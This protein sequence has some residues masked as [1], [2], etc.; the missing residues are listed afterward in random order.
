M[1]LTVD[2]LP[3]K[4]FITELT[5]RPPSNANLTKSLAPKRQL[6]L[7][8]TVHLAGLYLSERASVIFK[9][10]SLSPWPSL[11]MLV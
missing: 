6:S 1:G 9:F 5:G 7:P 8:W 11:P 3:T 2:I 4:L 10:C